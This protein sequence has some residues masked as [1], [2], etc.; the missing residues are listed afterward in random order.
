MTMMREFP[1]IIFDQISDVVT[2]V[3]QRAKIKPNQHVLVHMYC[4][5]MIIPMLDLDI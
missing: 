4:L 5:F 2:R 1:L 3:L